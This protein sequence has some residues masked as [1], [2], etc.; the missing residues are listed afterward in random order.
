[1]TLPTGP[2]GCQAST[3]H[4][5]QDFPLRWAQTV[6]IKGATSKQRGGQE[7]EEQ[8]DGHTLPPC[9]RA[10]LQKPKA[11]QVHS[12]SRP[13]A[14]PGTRPLPGVPHAPP[15]AEKHQD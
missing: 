1:M 13:G 7:R 12:G 15:E 14:T 2:G 8:S 3:S 4:H 9:E 6:P 5:G 10:L 11:W